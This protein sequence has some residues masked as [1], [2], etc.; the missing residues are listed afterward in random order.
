MSA[1]QR[2]RVNLPP[3]EH[4]GIV[5]KDMDRAIEYYSSTFGLGPFE[6]QEREAKGVTYKGQIGSFRLKLAFAQS[7]P[8]NIE[9]IQVLQGETPHTEFLREK[10][11]GIQHL[12]FRVDDLEGMLVELAKEGIEPVFHRMSPPI[13][14][15]YLNTDKIGGVMFELLEVKDAPAV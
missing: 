8:I 7:G 9:L 4:V 6:V 13:A 12:G 15:A 11:E 1:Q 14:F 3:L 5:V 10:G 2:P